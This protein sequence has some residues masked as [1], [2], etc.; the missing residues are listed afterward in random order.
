[1]ATVRLGNG[2]PGTPATLLP[3]KRFVAHLK[4]RRG[5]RKCIF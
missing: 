5:L 3:L 2:L 1:M 4:R